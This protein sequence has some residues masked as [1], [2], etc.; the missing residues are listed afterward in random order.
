MDSEQVIQ[1]LARRFSAPLPEFYRR[2]I[3]FWYDEEREFEDQL[4]GFELPGVKL[5]RLTGTNTFSV[6]KLLSTDDAD[7]DFLVYQPFGYDDP[8]EDWLLD[9]K[10]YSEEFRADLLSIWMEEMHIAAAPALRKTARE[11]RKFF[12]EK[13]RRAKV[14]ALA[15]GG[16]PSSP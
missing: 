1:D 6:K 10:L 15:E 5:A 2:R 12:G 7:S 8:E 9:V 16:G 14:A 13:R 11:Y 4:D 3:I